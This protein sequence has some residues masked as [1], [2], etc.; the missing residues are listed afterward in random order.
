[1]TDFQ[2]QYTTLRAATPNARLQE[3]A[4]LLGLPGE[5]VG[6][7]PYAWF[8]EEDCWIC[9]ETGPDGAICGL[10]RRYRDGSKKGMPGGMR[11]L[12]VPIDFDP[13][14]EVVHVVEGASDTA[15]ALAMGLRAVGRPSNT[16]GCAALVQL[17][18]YWKVLVVGE[19]D[20]K[21]GKKS[22]REQW[23]GRD[24]A[25]TVSDSLAETWGEPV[26][27]CLPPAGAKDLR[28]FYHEHGEAGGAL[29]R[30]HFDLFSHTVK[31]SD[32]MAPQSKPS[33]SLMVR[34]FADI[35]REEVEWLWPGVIPL[36]KVTLIAGNPGLGKSFFTCD[37]AARASTGAAWP[38]GTPNPNGKSRTLI[39]NCEDDAGDTIRGRL[40][41]AGADVRLV[42]WIDGARV[43]ETDEG[44]RLDSHLDL[45][46]RHIEDHPD[47]RLVTIDP[48]TAFTGDKDSD[49]TT[50]VRSV[51]RSL[52]ELAMRTGVAVVV[53]SHFNKSGGASAMFRTL[54]S[55]NWIAAVRM[56]WGVAADREEPSRRI[57]FPL[58]ANVA[59]DEGGFGYSIQQDD[60]GAV[61]MAWDSCR[62]VGISADEL[63]QPASEGDG[64]ALGDAEQFLRLELAD[65]PVEVK[66]LRKRAKEAGISDRTL[67]RAKSKL[68]VESDRFG[69]SPAVW[70]WSLPAKFATDSVSAE[71][72]HNDTDG[73]LRNSEPSTQHEVTQ[74]S[75][76]EPQ[77]CEERQPEG[78]GELQNTVERREA[79]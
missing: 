44:F 79:I 43:G 21:T 68:K 30:A 25:I 26:K 16:G 60:R 2:S 32:R 57:V 39:L 18:R 48:V 7:M 64:G 72:A 24:G 1:M 8:P 77:L 58:K 23:P 27:W 29:L 63:L 65:G 42:D 47:T 11:G 10:E 66:I 20:R 45:L 41:D 51:L 36:G 49:K 14:D 50:D 12:F 62:V 31:P 19:N 69:F 54:G 46:E 33:T 37:L 38:T 70:K 6:A 74:S 40:D 73:A 17:C 28:G 53:I 22:K 56:A 59:A 55:V 75:V 71:M 76:N 3:L 4:D 5:A 35:E 9:A 61:A 15:A 34:N 67:D 78:C 13:E 52:G